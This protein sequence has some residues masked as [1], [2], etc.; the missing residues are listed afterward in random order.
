MQ[1]CVLKHPTDATIADH[2]SDLLSEFHVDPSGVLKTHD[3]LSN[4][5]TWRPLGGAKIRG[6][7]ARANLTQVGRQLRIRHADGVSHYG[8]VEARERLYCRHVS[9]PENSVLHAGSSIVGMRHGLAVSLASRHAQIIDF[10]RPLLAAR[11]V[12]ADHGMAFCAGRVLVDAKTMLT[13]STDAAAAPSPAALRP[14]VLQRWRIE[15]AAVV[16]DTATKL[17]ELKTCQALFSA[18]GSRLLAIPHSSD[19]APVKPGIAFDLAQTPPRGLKLNVV[20]GGKPLAIADDGRRALVGDGPAGIGARLFTFDGRGRA[21]AEPL[22]S[23]SFLSVQVGA[24]CFAMSASFTPTGTRVATVDQ[25]RQA[26][27]WDVTEPM[28]S[29]L[30]KL[31]LSPVQS[32]AFRTD[33]QLTGAIVDR[34]GRTRLMLW[35]YSSLPPR[36]VPKD[37]VAAVRVAEGR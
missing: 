25:Q 32:L 16:A 11:T 34:D 26:H 3:D 19:D 30:T 27:L 13:L 29:L 17:S 31:T 28:P 14:A 24:Q 36:P 1:L 4:R 10:A 37:A 6:L 15:D 20:R 21:A 12:E 22:H 18:D 5:Y 7:V 35:D 2:L 8:L 23:G 33:W 9:G